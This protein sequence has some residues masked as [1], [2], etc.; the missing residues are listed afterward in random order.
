MEAL[1]RSVEGT[2]GKGKT[3]KVPPKKTEA[4][5]RPKRKARG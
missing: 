4:A 1:R 5:S 2:G 3:A